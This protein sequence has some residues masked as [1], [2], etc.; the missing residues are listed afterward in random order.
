MTTTLIRPSAADLAVETVSDLDDPI[1][2]GARYKPIL[3]ARLAELTRRLDTIEHDLDEPAPQDTE[4]RATE[5]EGDEVLEGIGIAGLA[6]T[7][8]IRAALNRI[9][10]GV[11]GICVA[12]GEP[13][14]EERLRAVPHAARCRNCA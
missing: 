4:D 7:R 6:E 1:A 11:F 13:I 8:M 12:C 10:A 5:R 9:E 3:E 14:S 2:R